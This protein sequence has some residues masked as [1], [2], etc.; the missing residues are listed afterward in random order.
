MT[1]QARRLPALFLASILLLLALPAAYAREMVSAARNDVMLRKGPS[2]RAAATWAVDR[3]YPMQV[4]SRK[5]GW[6]H[7]R[8]FENDRAWVLQS[9]TNKQAHVVSTASTLN[10]RSTPSLKGRVVAKVA[11]GDVLR[12]VERRGEW[13]KVRTGRGTTGWVSRKLVWG[14]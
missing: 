2:A 3:G 9:R 1:L 6:L 7:V 5:G 10:V 14:W 13:I 11:Y 12:T 4:L 8:D